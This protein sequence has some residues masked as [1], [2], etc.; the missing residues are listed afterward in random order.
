MHRL[1]SEKETENREIRETIQLTIASKIIKCLG[2][3]LPKETKDH[4]IE[5]Y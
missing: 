1:K 3:N 5:N 4:F 2:I